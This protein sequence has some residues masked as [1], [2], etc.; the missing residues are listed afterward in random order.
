MLKFLSQAATETSTASVEDAAADVVVAAVLDELHAV[1]ESIIVPAIKAD[2]TF[3]ITILFLPIFW[4]VEFS[5]DCFVA[6]PVF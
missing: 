2:N 4:Q 1:K 5:P 6:L 3:F